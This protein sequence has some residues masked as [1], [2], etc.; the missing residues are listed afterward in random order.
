M[1]AINPKTSQKLKSWNRV[2]QEWVDVGEDIQ[3][4]KKERAERQASNGAAALMGFSARLM[5][6]SKIKKDEKHSTSGSGYPKCFADYTYVT[7]SKDPFLMPG[8]ILFPPSL[9]RPLLISL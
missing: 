8:S 7:S 2:T 3:L 4:R 6:Q 5:E 1:V 9:C